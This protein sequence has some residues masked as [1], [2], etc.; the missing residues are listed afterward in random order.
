MD[1]YDSKKVKESLMRI[2]SNIESIEMNL[3]SLMRIES[4]IKSIESEVNT[5]TNFSAASK[6][7]SS[8]KEMISILKDILHALKYK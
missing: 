1:E 8:Q 2:E 7:L 3:K 6:N 5:L 4:V